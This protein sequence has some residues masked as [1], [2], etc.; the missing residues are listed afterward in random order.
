MS[1]ESQSAPTPTPQS[2]QS[3]TRTRAVRAAEQMARPPSNT[4][5]LGL[6][7]RYWDHEALI[8]GIC[9]R[10]RHPYLSSS[11]ERFMDPEF[12]LPLKDRKKAYKFLMV[13][14]VIVLFSNKL[15]LG[16]I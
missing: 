8:R 7:R 4:Y 1:Q 9:D 15:K 14:S 11:S 3:T 16:P 5:I 13:V 6:F 10:C 2:P 12:L